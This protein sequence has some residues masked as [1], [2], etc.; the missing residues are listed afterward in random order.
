MPESKTSTWISIAHPEYLRITDEY[1][2]AHYGGNQAW[3]RAFWQRQAGCG[4][5]V[6]ATLCAYLAKTRPACA[7]LCGHDSSRKAGFLALMS[8]L[9]EYVTPGM[10][11]SSVEIF[12]E[13]ITRYAASKSIALTCEVLDI[14]KEKEN[15]PSKERV[16]TF[17][18]KAFAED[19]PI[20]FQNY[21]NGELKNLESWHWVTLVAYEEG[22][23]F[24]EMYDQSRRDTLDIPLYLATAARAGKFVIA[25]PG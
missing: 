20:A 21:S 12:T 10:G 16:A 1:G 5:T 24:A 8:D 22:T 11:G 19:L 4:P 15:R 9:W 7:L 3:Y 18:H 13:G 14:P 6:A 2:R 17:F 23:F 25:R